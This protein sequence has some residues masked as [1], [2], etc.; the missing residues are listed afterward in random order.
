[1]RGCGARTARAAE[2]I[3]VTVLP[4]LLVILVMSASVAWAGAHKHSGKGEKG[5]EQ[6]QSASSDDPQSSDG[7]DSRSD[8][9]DSSG[10]GP[11]DGNDSSGG[12]GGSGDSGPSDQPPADG[13]AEPPADGGASPP[14]DEGPVP[15]TDGAP[16]E[17]GGVVPP[18]GGSDVPP[19]DGGAVPPVEAK[20]FGPAKK[21]VQ[22][23]GKRQRVVPGSY[24]VVYKDSVKSPDSAT[25]ELA[26]AAGFKTRHLYEKAIKGF[27]A[28][29]STAQVDQVS[30]DV[31]VAFITPDIEVKA[32]QTVPLA[33]GEPTPPTGVRRIQAASDTSAHEASGAAVAVLDSGI[34]LGN[35]DLNAAS[36]KNCVDGQASSQDDNG[37]GTH[38]AGTIAARN[39][40]SGVVGVAPGTK[41]Y[42][43]K[44][45]GSSGAGSWAQV[46][47][48]IDWVTANASK[49]GIKVANMSFG[50]GGSPIATCSSTN[51]PV[52]KAICSSTKAG[53]T[54]VAAAGNDSKAFDAS[55]SP[56]VPAA[57]P[58]VIAVAA[59]TDSDGVP[60]GTGGS[61]GCRGGESDDTVASFSNYAGTSAGED[62]TIAAPGVCISSDALGGG[63]STKSGTSMA[64]PHI[65]G[66]V[67][68]C[69]SDGDTNGDCAG[70]SPGQIIDTLRSTARDH[71]DG[72]HG[73]GFTG[74]P[75]N[76]PS[77]GRYFGFLDWVGLAE[78]GD[79]VAPTVSAV[80]PL[81]G[82][83]DF[84]TT[85]GVSVTFSKPMDQASVQG[86]FSLTRSG[87]AAVAGSFSWI[88]N[89]MTFVPN[90]D[91]ARG[92]DY[93]A[94]LTT[95]ARDLAG[96][97]LGSQ[98]RWTFSTWSKTS[99]AP[100]SVDMLTGALAGGDQT[101]LARDDD[102]Y[103]SVDST[104]TSTRK[105]S[106]QARFTGLPSRPVS[107]SLDYKGKSSHTCKQ[108]L[109][110]RRWKDGSWVKL[111]ANKVGTTELEI[112][113]PLG[114]TLADY[115]SSTGEAVVRVTCANSS[116]SFQSMGDLLR[117]IYS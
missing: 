90:A 8:G 44:V 69:L 70:K 108:T 50:G 105:S 59:V 80:T 33:G 78:G 2:S 83:I 75:D 110:V 71:T 24:I 49:L 27:A 56:I 21:L 48:G 85:G 39:D 12:D 61:P 52:Y 54:Y 99:L 9:G 58:E 65:A 37:H 100:G 84:P 55:S 72:D 51:D 40:G 31:D 87:G 60:G 109:F 91:L 81:D 20:P 98:Q 10:P 95:A 42:A 107:L 28:E 97:P 102:V 93:E 94:E 57:Y 16:P 66:A 43:V 14:G 25:R 22:P 96:N 7:N 111:S 34:D 86:A 1:M 79:T 32:F 17:D 13:G 68:V 45:L 4:A 116:T 117:L 62:H 29:L 63:T 103:L 104:S 11:S 36:G 76:N 30:A 53:V 15:P 77:S 67:A 74:D 26:K 106:W 18:D 88:G 38:V 19:A 92:A 41:L 6:S 112:N 114:G 23:T 3:P 5:D 46:I 47:C 64:S 115:V 113:K 101:A 35:S 82:A 73:Y 89:T